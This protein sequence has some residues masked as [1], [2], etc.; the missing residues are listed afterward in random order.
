MAHAANVMCDTGRFGHAETDVAVGVGDETLA[1]MN[2]RMIASLRTGQSARSNVCSPTAHQPVGVPR[3]VAWRASRSSRRA[4]TTS[5]TSIA[6]TKTN[7]TNPTAR[8]GQ[9]ALMATHANIPSVTMLTGTITKIAT[10]VRR[11]V[12]ALGGGSGRRHC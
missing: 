5:Q 4:V 3:P 6:T 1:A 9:E 8:F 11:L 7:P 10:V 12:Q 2:L